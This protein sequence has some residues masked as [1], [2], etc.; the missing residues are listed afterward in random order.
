[1]VYSLHGLLPNK[2]EDNFHEKLFMN[3]KTNS[4]SPKLGD[5][6]RHLLG[7]TF[8]HVLCDDVNRLLG[9]HGI[10]LHQLVVPEFLHDL[11]LLQEGLWGHGARLQSLHCHFGGAIPSPCYVQTR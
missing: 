4:Q 11:S 3:S 10:E 5:D 7:F 9:D 8:A 1:M 6:C 2:I